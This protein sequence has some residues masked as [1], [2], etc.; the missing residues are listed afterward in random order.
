MAK[1]LTTCRICKKRDYCRNCE[2]RESCYWYSNGHKSYHAIS[3]EGFVCKHKDSCKDIKP[4]YRNI[5]DSIWR[6][7][8]D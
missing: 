8:D 5:N 4:E 2:L 7:R 1:E 6:R 3:C